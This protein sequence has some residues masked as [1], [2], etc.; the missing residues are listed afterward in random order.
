MHM[1][2]VTLQYKNIIN[3]VINENCNDNKNMITVMCM[4]A[5]SID[6]NLSTAI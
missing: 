4:K 6:M 3:K 2:Q 1:L 5:G